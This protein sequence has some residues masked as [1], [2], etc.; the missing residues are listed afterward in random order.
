MIKLGVQRIDRNKMEFEIAEYNE[1]GEL[2]GYHYF[3]A[4]VTEDGLGI[5][6][7]TKT[8][9]HTEITEF[10]GWLRRLRS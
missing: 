9:H 6:L 8:L 2:W 1:R 3:P 7:D 5:H 10:T 4:T